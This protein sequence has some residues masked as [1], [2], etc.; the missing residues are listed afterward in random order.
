MLLEEKTGGIYWLVVKQLK[1][2]VVGR[3]DRRN[4]L[5]RC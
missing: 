1:G 5:A 2:Y 3:E 4:L